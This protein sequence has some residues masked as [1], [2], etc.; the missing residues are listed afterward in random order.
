MSQCPTALV[1]ILKMFFLTKTISIPSTLTQIYETKAPL[2]DWSPQLP[3]LLPSVSQDLSGWELL[4]Q[5][6]L[7]WSSA[8][9]CRLGFRRH[10]KRT[11]IK[12]SVTCYAGYWRM[13]H[14]EHPNEFS[15]DPIWAYRNIKNYEV[16]Y[17]MLHGCRVLLFTN[18]AK[19]ANVNDVLTLNA[20]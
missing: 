11:V 9:P 13:L 15:Y 5:L 2:A 16:S 8:F 3:S 20:L 7:S 14:S 19:L 12:A 10:L 18:L 4:S 17:L 6:P 1:R